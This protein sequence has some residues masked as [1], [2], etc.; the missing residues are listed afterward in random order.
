MFLSKLHNVNTF[1][2]VNI[3]EQTPQVQPEIPPN[4]SDFGLEPPA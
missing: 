3:S 4:P 2:S 1:H